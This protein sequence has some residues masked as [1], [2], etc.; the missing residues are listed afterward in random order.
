MSNEVITRVKPLEEI[1][2]NFHKRDK[3][4][5][6]VD[7]ANLYY[8]CL[9]TDIKLDFDDLRKVLSNFMTVRA[10]N[11][12]VAVPPTGVEDKRLIK[13][14]KTPSYLE[15]NGWRLHRKIADLEDIP[16]GGQRIRKGNVD[17]DLAVTMIDELHCANG[18]LDHIILFSGDKDY[19]R[20]VE[21][22]KRSARVTVVSTDNHLSKELKL[23]ADEIISLE[24][25]KP[26][27]DYRRYDLT[28]KANPCTTKDMN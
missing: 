15:H 10:F 1:F 24:A 14:L 27:I 22:L 8:S 20:A 23:A 11:Y 4:A 2:S 25:L 18:S 28:Y 19:E 12:F 9:E 26:Y 3:A 21:V 7:A 13:S 6:Y 5:V 16:G 17:V